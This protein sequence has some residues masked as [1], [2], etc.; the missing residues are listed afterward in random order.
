MFTKVQKELINDL[1]DLFADYYKDVKWHD[2]GFYLNWHPYANSKHEV[3]DYR[4]F[5]LDLR[6][7]AS[8]IWSKQNYIANKLYNSIIKMCKNNH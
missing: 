6:W 2:V 7:H 4:R 1:L 3:L 8:R 5:I